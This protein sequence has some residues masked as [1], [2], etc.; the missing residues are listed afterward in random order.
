MFVL[1]GIENEVQQCRGV[2]SSWE[3]LRIAVD[4]WKKVYTVQPLVYEEWQL[5]KFEEAIC[6]DWVYVPV[7]HLEVDA[8][9]GHFPSS[10]YLGIN[11]VGVAYETD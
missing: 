4:Y 7:S 9:G 1:F 10:K 3:A 2:Y 5:D 6:W 11:L 8:N